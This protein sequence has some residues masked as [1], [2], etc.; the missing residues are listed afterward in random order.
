MAQR[1]AVPSPKVR[2]P[3]APATLI[4]R[5]RLLRLLDTRVPV[6]G[7]TVPDVTLL[8]APPGSGKTTLLST[9]ASRQGGMQDA[10]P[11]GRCV[12]WATLDN[13]DNDIFL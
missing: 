7:G 5:E 2:V 9:W 3:V 12:A 13:D 10:P 1:S 6:Q 11:A 8:S 4:P